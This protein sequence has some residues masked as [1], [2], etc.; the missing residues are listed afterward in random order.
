MEDDI[1]TFPRE[2]LV[3]L[4]SPHFFLAATSSSRSDVVRRKTFVKILTLILFTWK[5]SCW[6]LLAKILSSN[7]GLWDAKES[8]WQHGSSAVNP[9]TTLRVW[10]GVSTFGC[11]FENISAPKTRIN[12]SFAVLEPC[13]QDIFGHKGLSGFYP[14]QKDLGQGARIFT[15]IKS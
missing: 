1:K 6:P 3:N 12:L 5:K 4:T 9:S 8:A 2:D 13:C 15:K 11:F 14:H 7:W 10:F